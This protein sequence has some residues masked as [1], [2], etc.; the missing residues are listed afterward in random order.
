[1]A[2]SGPLGGT[3]T[4]SVSDARGNTVEKRQY[5]SP[6]AL[7]GL[8]DATSYTYDHAG[9]LTGVTGSRRIAG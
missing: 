1:M 4:Q 3:V 2:V 5:Q 6:T 8:F 9:R 7:T